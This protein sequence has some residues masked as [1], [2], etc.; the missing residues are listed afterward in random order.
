[1]SV[2]PRSRS[3]DKLFSTMVALYIIVLCLSRYYDFPCFSRGSEYDIYWL[4]NLARLHKLLDTDSDV[5]LAGATSNQYEF[6]L[7]FAKIFI[8]T[9]DATTLTRRLQNRQPGD[10]GMLPKELQEIL[11]TFEGVYAPNHRRRSY[12]HRCHTASGNRRR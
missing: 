12:P 10:Y 5:F 4:W 8:L 7:L 3:D 9:M 2:W 1:M 6:Y 11:R